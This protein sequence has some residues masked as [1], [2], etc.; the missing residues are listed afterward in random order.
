MASRSL[1]RVMLIGRLGKD[2]ETKFLPTGSAMTKFTVAT[3][4]SYKDKQSG[5]WR[6]TTEW[7]NIVAWKQES[8][9]NYLT[10]GKQVYVEG[11]LTTRNYDDKDGNKRYVTEVTAESI[12]LLGGDRQQA[13]K[14]DF[15]PDFDAPVSAPRQAVRPVAADAGITDEDLPF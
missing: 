13:A 15:D 5:E 1:N 3:D 8:V 14:P 7:H 6:T 4:S 11:R 9:A 10:K 12:I 2:A